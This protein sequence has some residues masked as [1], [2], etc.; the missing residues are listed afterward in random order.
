MK[1]Q[2]EISGER[3]EPNP[4]SDDSLWTKKQAANFLGITIRTLETWLKE[5]R[6]PRFKI[7]R[8]VRLR[9]QDVLAHLNAN[10]RIG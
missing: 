6:L 1:Q 3:D 7:K 4:G 2:H 9:R 10:N 5:G 8:T